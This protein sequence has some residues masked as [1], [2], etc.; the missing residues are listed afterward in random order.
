MALVTKPNTFSA[1]NTILASEHNTNFDTL[2]NDY[3]G[4]ITNANLSG[5]AGITDSNLAQ[6]TTAS[7]VSGAA[8]TSLSSTPSGAGVLPSANGGVP[9]GGIITWSGAISAIPTGWVICDGTNSTPDLT[10]LFIIHAD[11]DSGGTR[12]VGDTGGSHTTNLQ[13]NHSGSTGSN[14][15]DNVSSGSD[16]DTVLNGT[17]THSVGNDLSTTVA[18]IPAFYALAY[19]MKT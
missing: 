2:Y 18:T 14:A 11:A 8:L 13:H 16:A 10:N 12:D 6:I 19:I 1:G 7:K 3:N 9:A 15:A 4:N 5:S 17:H